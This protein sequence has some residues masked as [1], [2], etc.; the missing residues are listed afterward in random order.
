MNNDALHMALLID[1]FGD[2]LTD[3]QR[4]YLD[5]YC[6]EDLSLAEIAERAGI[7]RQGVHDIITRARKS[8][9]EIERKTGVVHRWLEEKEKLACA[10]GLSETL[11]RLCADD[12][13]AALARELTATLKS[14][15][16][17]HA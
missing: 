4:E 8:L 13:S 6:N 14:L 5:L 2:L 3:K 12:E 1:F 9:E 10:H 16:E 7:S 15:M 11:A 17:S